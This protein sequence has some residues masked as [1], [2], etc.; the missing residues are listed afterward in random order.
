MLLFMIISLVILKILSDAYFTRHYL[1]PTLNFMSIWTSSTK[2]QIRLFSAS[3]M[4][5][6]GAYDLD[7]RYF[8]DRSLPVTRYATIPLNLISK[9]GG[10]HA[11]SFAEMTQVDDADWKIPINPDVF[12][13]YPQGL[14]LP[15][16]IRNYR[17]TGRV[18]E[19]PI[20]LPNLKVRNV[21]SSVCPPEGNKGHNHDLVVI[22]KSAVYNFENRQNF[23]QLYA[24]LRNNSVKY[25]YRVG[26][27][28]FVGLPSSARDNVF[29]RDGFNITLPDRA[30]SSLINLTSRRAEILTRLEEEV[31]QHD[32][33]VVGDFEDTYFNLS[34]KLHLTFVWA[35]RFCC[36]HP[37]FMFLD[38]DM[39]FNEQL[40]YTVLATLPG[41]WRRTVAIA[42]TRWN[43]PT[44]RPSETPISQKWALAKEE[45]PWPVHAP[46]AN[47]YFYILGYDHVA[48]L[49]LAMFFTKP[50]FIDDVWLGLNFGLIKFECV[51]GSRKMSR[52]SRIGILCFTCRVFGNSRP[53]KSAGFSDIVALPTTP[54]DLVDDSRRFLPWQ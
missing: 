51:A 29:Q 15:A 24:H 30:G 37:G 16:V 6:D 4:V 45:V 39:A 36:E 54:L 1:L 13:L 38:D 47:G 43:S 3:K 27:V 35:A 48:D 9:K 49:A 25:P 11:V 50:I 42:K 18:P 19:I 34:L 21:S 8:L 44:V 14:S 33:L 7:F 17:E 10:N 40:L 28:F 53:E 22:V 52:N 2:H 31:L 23:R 32:D 26:I 5:K 12:N 20:N 41:D 46:Y